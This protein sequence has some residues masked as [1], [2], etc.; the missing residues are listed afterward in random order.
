VGCEGGLRWLGARVEEG[1]RA[2]QYEMDG[3]MGTVSVAWC[4]AG[5]TAMEQGPRPSRCPVCLLYPLP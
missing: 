2:Q 3:P 1:A 4:R 5:C